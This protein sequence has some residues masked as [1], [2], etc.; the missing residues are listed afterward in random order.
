MALL[1]F[2]PIVGDLINAGSSHYENVRSQHFQRD[3]M[4]EQMAWS[5]KMNAQQQEWQEMMWNKSNEYNSPIEQLERAKAAGINP[6][7]LVNGGANMGSATMA[8]QPQIPSAPAGMSA[9][10]F[11]NIL[12]DLG[13]DIYNAL[14]MS[15][16][17]ELLEAQKKNIEA[18]TR[19]QDLDSER[20]TME[21]SVWMTDWN[22]KQAAATADINLK[23]EQLNEVQF[24]VD[25]LL[26]QQEEMNE[27]Q[28]NNML[29]AA[30]KISKEI[31]VLEKQK[32]LVAEQIKTQQAEQGLIGA[33]Q[34]E[35]N[36]RRN[37]VDKQ[38]TA[39]QY[40]NDVAKV[41]ANIANEYGI[42]VSQLDAIEQINIELAKA[43]ATEEQ[44]S[45][46]WS[47]TR[48]E[49]LERFKSGLSKTLDNPLGT[50]NSVGNIVRG[51]GR[52]KGN[53]PKQ[54]YGT[55]TSTSKST[56]NPQFKPKRRVTTYYE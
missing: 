3:M 37:L 56:P 43:G 45:N 53:V 13:G 1:D 19:G 21:N 42:D 6:N 32:A 28:L 22:I 40:E 48:G 16:Q 31:A 47:A 30:Q 34:E 26:P 24:N 51:R 44:I 10:G 29:A 12:G 55:M 54:S 41:K 2:I 38:A 50:A 14:L 11:P 46:F 39:Q 8:Q 18:N 4:R 25:V 15:K 20:K 33:Q 9:P 27:Q 49:L 23:K 7:A 17:R 35:T 52:A 5:E 36:A